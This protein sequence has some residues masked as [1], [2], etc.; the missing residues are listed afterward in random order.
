MSVL[1]VA[2]YITPRTLPDLEHTI[3][4]NCRSELILDEEQWLPWSRFL[5]LSSFVH[6]NADEHAPAPEADHFQYLEG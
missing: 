3:Q 6:D 2:G 1:S 5:F 4:I